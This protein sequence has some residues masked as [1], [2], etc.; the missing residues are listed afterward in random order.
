[1][2]RQFVLA[3]HSPRRRQLLRAAGYAFEEVPSDIAEI[4]SI[5]L[6]L[7]EMTLAN[8]GRKGLAVADRKPGQLVLAADTLV[9]LDCTIFGKPRNR[10]EARTILLQLSGKTHH[11]GTAVWLGYGR[12]RFVTFTVWSAVRLRRLNEEVIETYLEKINP[13]DKA[14][15]YAAQEHGAEII[16]WV[17][18]SFSNVVGLPL[19]RTI[20]ALSTFGIKPGQGAP[21]SDSSRA[22]AIVFGGSRRRTR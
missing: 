5:H 4:S 2:D 1:M 12:R 20:A 3:S 11:V 7:G 21:I 10:K 8:A 15:A 6:S 18:G 13:L 17:E 19:E 16:E 14:G 9:A 22:D